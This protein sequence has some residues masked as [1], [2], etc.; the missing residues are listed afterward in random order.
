M[1]VVQQSAY[2]NYIFLFL[3]PLVFYVVNWNNKKQVGYLL[4][5]N[6]LCVVHPS[7]WWRLD[8]PKYLAPSDIWVSAS[9]VLDYL[10]QVSIVILTGY[11]VWLA[12]SKKVVS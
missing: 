5:F 7:Y 2:S 12:A 10:M 11:F 9:S 6:I 1:M 3:I 8:M 4:V